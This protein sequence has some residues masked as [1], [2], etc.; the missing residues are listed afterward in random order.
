MSGFDT[1]VEVFLALELLVAFPPVPQTVIVQPSRG[2]VVH[3]ERGFDFQRL[4][5][6]ELMASKR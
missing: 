3:D 5:S 6:G 2:R 4:V 1:L